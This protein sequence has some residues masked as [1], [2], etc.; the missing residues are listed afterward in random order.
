MGNTGQGNDHADAPGADVFNEALGLLGKCGV[1]P[2][3]LAY[4]ADVGT[5]IKSLGVGEFSTLDKLRP[6]AMLLN[7]QLAQVDGIPVIVSEQMAKS[8]ADGKVTDGG[9][10]NTKGRLLVVNRTQWCLGF[11]RE[12][13]IE[14]TRDIQKRQNIMVVRMWLKL[15]LYGGAEAL[16]R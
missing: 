15:A 9:N 4:I 13:M 8:D 10:S 5:Y 11:R 6:Q 12:L 16:G 7:G 3:K 14:T 1:H 2:S